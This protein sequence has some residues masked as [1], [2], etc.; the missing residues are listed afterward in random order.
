MFIAGAKI[1]N[2]ERTESLIDICTKDDEEDFD[3]VV[4]K[5]GLNTPIAQEIM[6][7]AAQEVLPIDFT[8][9]DVK[10]TLVSYTFNSNERYY[11]TYR[12]NHVSEK[13]NLINKRNIIVYVYSD[14]C[15]C[16]SCFKEYNYYSFDRI[17]NVCAVVALR[18]EPKKSV[19]IDLQHCTRCGKHFIDKQSLA[20][21]RKKYGE[22]AIRTLTAPSDDLFARD[23]SDGIEFNPDTVLS[24]NGYST[25]LSVPERLRILDQMLES[26]VAKAEIKDVLTRFIF[27][28]GERC[29]NLKEMDNA[30]S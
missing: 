17:Q 29:G 23:G 1:I 7:A 28:R 9:N 15:R 21:Y 10:Y 18:A 12:K 26:G 6:K 3:A 27:Q 24:R 8:C 16:T 2:D 20:L 13:H 22:L 30:T 5:V 19:E 4:A 14:R 25:S 11:N